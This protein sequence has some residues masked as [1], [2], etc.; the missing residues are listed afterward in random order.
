MERGTLLLVVEVLLLVLLDLPGDVL[1]LGL[2]LPQPLRRLT[3]FPLRLL[4]GA[5]DDNSCILHY[6]CVH[7]RG[8]LRKK[9][10]NPY[11]KVKRP[12]L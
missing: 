9:M 3:R 7:I 11:A 2:L 12:Y 4:R 5:V 10:T 6:T 1:Q 8:E